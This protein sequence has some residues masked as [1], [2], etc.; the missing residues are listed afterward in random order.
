MFAGFST[1]VPEEQDVKA[2]QTTAAIKY[3]IDKRTIASPFTGKH[4]YTL[5]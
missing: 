2:T 3:L 5:G 4:S 1:L